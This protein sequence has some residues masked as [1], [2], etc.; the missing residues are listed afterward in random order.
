MVD[1]L[2]EVLEDHRR[3]E[4]MRSVDGL[5]KS[6]RGGCMA[7]ITS[8]PHEFE[9]TPFPAERYE[10]HSLCEFND[11]EIQRFIAG[12]RSIRE[13]SEKAASDANKDL[14]DAIEARP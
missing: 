2:D 5:A 4:L 14:W 10:R 7:L 12:W 9:K 8:R 1:G 6:L 13:T 11:D 3:E